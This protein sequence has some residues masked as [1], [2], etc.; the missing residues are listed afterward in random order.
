MKSE[1]QAFRLI[2]CVVLLVLAAGISTYA[3]DGKLT[4][5]VT[6]RQTYVFVDGRALG[7]AS[8]HRSLSLSAGNH[9]IDLAN[10]G[11]NP[12]SRTVTITAG[13]T[14]NLE[15]TLEAVAGT[16]SGPFGAMT[17]EGADRNAVLLNGKTPDYFVGHGDEFNHNWWWKQELV[18]P[19]GTHQVTVLTAD[20]EVWSGPV[21]VPA[22]QRVVVDVPKGVR[23]TVPWPRGEKLTGIPRFKT[24][25]ASATVAVAKPSA[26]L[27]V[28]AAQ[29]NCG[30]SSQ[31]KWTSSD[32]PHVEITPVGSVAPSG[33][34]AIQPKQTTTYQLTASGPGGTTTS[35]ATVNV[36]SA[37]QADLGLS[38]AE[39][40]YKRVGDKVVETGSPALNWNATNASAVSI[41][42]LGTVT[43]NGS[44]TLQVAPHKTDPGPVDE[45]VNYTLTATNGCGGTETR[46][47]ALH[48][49]GT[50]EPLE[51][52]LTMRSVYFPT[53]RPRSI[54]TYAGLL[55]SEQDT[56]KSIAED[57]KKLLANKPDAHLVLSGH[58]DK[59]GPQAYNKPLSER[60]A[61]LAKR[62]LIE[63]GVPEANLETQAFGKEQNLSDDQV[64]DL[65]AQNPNVSEAQRQAVIERMPT[66]V[67]AYN[68][69]VDLTLSTTGQESARQYPFNT[70][71]Y[72]RLVDRN[73]PAKAGGVELAAE[74][75][76][77]K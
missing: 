34:Q 35:S 69:R 57:F 74:R 50:I 19:P 56:L 76:K 46:T 5:H 52:K 37:I 16:V 12:T 62:F 33:E 4:I 15:V 53:D 31:I 40:H 22:N 70:D 43:T 55:Q 45:T 32:A 60:R 75:A 67:L 2:A 14:T 51:T 66:I 48:I 77:M 26:Q 44:R 27:T 72:A 59:R 58:A 73:G 23:K 36:N 7:E 54:K 61:E 17:I 39:V 71:D 20:K 42:P 11:Y 21:E 25:T 38:P 28:T 49:V 29:L 1:S 63:Q 41:E 9:K 8:H 3:Q 64:K 13:Q 18:V 24:G 6:P 47:A 68:R 65:I 30:D 10:Y